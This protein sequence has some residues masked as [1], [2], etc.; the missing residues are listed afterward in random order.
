MNVAV[1]CVLSKGEHNESLKKLYD[2]GVKSPQLLKSFEQ[3]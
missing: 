1:Y 3:K 2:F